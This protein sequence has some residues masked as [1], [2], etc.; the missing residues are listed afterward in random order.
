MGKYYILKDGI[1]TK[2]MKAA[3]KILRTMKRAHAKDKM[4]KWPPDKKV[5]ES[6]SDPP[7]KNMCRL[8]GHNHFWKEC[9][10][11]LNSNK[12]NE[13]HYSK[14]WEQERAGPP[15]QMRMKLLDR[16]KNNLN[17]T[18]E[19]GTASTKNAKRFTVVIPAVP[20]TMVYGAATFSQV[21][22]SLGSFDDFFAFGGQCLQGISF[23]ITY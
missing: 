8:N 13:T 1:H 10:N 3:K 15:A 11:N 17:Q 4:E 7:K 9:P 18:A 22:N 5:K 23:V 12:Y 6:A 21:R 20:A 14:V 16:T 2:R 19:G